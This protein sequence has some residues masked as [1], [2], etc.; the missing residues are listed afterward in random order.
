MGSLVYGKKV[1]AS[2]LL[3]NRYKPMREAADGVL[4]QRIHSTTLYI[5]LRRCRVEMTVPAFI[6][7]WAL[8]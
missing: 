4:K 2:A 5:W 7:S 8:Q 6:V 1:W 3:K